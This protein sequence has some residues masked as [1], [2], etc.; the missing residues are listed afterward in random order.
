MTEPRTLQGVLTQ[1]A[2]GRP[3]IHGQPAAGAADASSRAIDWSVGGTVFASLDQAGN[4]V[5]LRLDDAVAK[6]ATRTPD[7]APSSRGAGWVRFAPAM[8]DD[9][10]IDRLEAWFAF[11]ARHALDQA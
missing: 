10:A 9:Q 11:A 4:A 3:E 7:T 5:E 2:A 1:L 8:L 6:A